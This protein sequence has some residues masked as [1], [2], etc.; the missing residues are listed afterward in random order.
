[1]KEFEVAP[2]TFEFEFESPGHLVEVRILIQQVCWEILHCSHP[3]RP[4][5][6]SCGHI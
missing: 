6:Q 1:M 5:W 3:Q 4:R 2:M